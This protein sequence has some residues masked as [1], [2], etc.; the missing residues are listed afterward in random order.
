MKNKVLFSD[1]QKTS[2]TKGID[3]LKNETENLKYRSILLNNKVLNSE[4]KLVKI[5]INYLHQKTSSTK[6]ID[7]LKEKTI[8]H[9]R[10]MDK[11]PIR[12]IVHDLNKRIEKET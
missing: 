7:T 5:K 6:T 8:M 11:D 9:N 1:I 2:L 12:I 3:M 10:K 4:N